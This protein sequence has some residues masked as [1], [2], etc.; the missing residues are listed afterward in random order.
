MEYE[1]GR[2]YHWFF[3]P[4]KMDESIEICLKMVSLGCIQGGV[5]SNLR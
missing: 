2:I 1:H 4:K 5:I 3:F